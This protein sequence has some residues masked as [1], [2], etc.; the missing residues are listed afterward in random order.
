MGGAQCPRMILPL[1]MHRPVNPYLVTGLGFA[2]SE[3]YHN[4]RVL[5]RDQMMGTVANYS[6]AR[7]YAYGGWIPDDIHFHFDYSNTRVFGGGENILTETWM[8]KVRV[9]DVFQPRPDD[10]LLYPQRT[11]C[12]DSPS[13]WAAIGTRE[14]E[15]VS[16]GGGVSFPPTTSRVVLTAVPAL[17]P[18]IDVRDAQPGFTWGGPSFFGMKRLEWRQDRWQ[19]I[20][21]GSTPLVEPVI[22]S[23]PPIRIL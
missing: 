3:A 19:F 9:D 12:E 18:T 5:V 13:Q 8:L 20:W 15:K 1:V 22:S 11:F 17:V 16:V 14:I 23:R 10:L 7:G 4:A 21:E 2:S 6:G